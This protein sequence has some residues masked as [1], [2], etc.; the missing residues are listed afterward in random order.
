M[1][2]GEV[3][4]SSFRKVVLA[5]FVGTVIEWYDFYLYGT[6]AALVFNKLF[7]PSFDPLTGTLAAFTTYAVGFFARP[8]GGIV[9]GHYG[10][11]IGRKSMLVATLML[12][13]VSTFLI[14]ILPT[15]NQIG[16][17]APILL[18]VLRFAQGFAV[19]GEWGGAVL[20]VVEHDSGNRRGFYASLSQSGTSVGLLLAMVV[21]S[22]F[23]S[24]P[25]ASFLSWGWRVPFLLGIVLTG[26]G[27]FIR[28]KIA[29]SPLFA[30][31]AVSRTKSRAPILEALQ[32]YRKSLLI[33]LG[34][35]VAENAA[36]YIFTVFL[37]SY[38]TVQ[39]GLPRQSVLNGVI[40]ASALGMI[41]MPFFGGLSDRVGRRPVYMGGA[42]ALALLAFPIFWMVDTGN[43]ILVW[44]AIIVG[45]SF[46]VI[47]MFAPE[48]AFFS[49]LFRTNVRYSGASFG[50]QLAA[51]LG[52]GL[53]PI[54]ATAL[55]KWTG[56]QSW[57]IAIYLIFLAVL[58]L[59]AVYFS[60]ETFRADI[61]DTPA[62][63]QAGATPASSPG[64]SERL[65]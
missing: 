58:G 52:G 50:Y 46:C 4:R 18:V 38:A 60:S 48:A 19:G 55:L 5:S 35:R 49:E 7:F 36:S 13:G 20:M 28:V 34:V 44:T 40:A 24:L 23:A 2:V 59:A 29:E 42:L 22:F 17:M 32:L 56:G 51:A 14:G 9:F 15:Y 26:V 39:L 6:A 57:S 30:E 12:M 27:L 11:K 10:D 41:T 64:P 1:A 8:L 25:E 3:D 65:A 43:L 61:A 53:A 21:F 33:I 47:A 45:F 62:A 63:I 54:I 16:A 37:L 31:L